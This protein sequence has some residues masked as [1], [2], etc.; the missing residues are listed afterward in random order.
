[1]NRFKNCKRLPNEEQLHKRDF[2]KQYPTVSTDR[3]VHENRTVLWVLV[4]PTQKQQPLGWAF[5]RSAY[6]MQDTKGAY[7][8][9]YTAVAVHTKET[10]PPNNTI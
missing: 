1:M 6:G 2:Y 3:L 7:N 9:R 10:Y 4:I 5:L 8:L